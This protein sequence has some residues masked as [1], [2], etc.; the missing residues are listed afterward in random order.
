MKEMAQYHQRPIHSPSASGTGDQADTTP[1][2]TR[3]ESSSS[4]AGFA[5]HGSSASADFSWYRSGSASSVA[6]ASQSNRVS[7]YNEAAAGPT[8]EASYQLVIVLGL[9]STIACLAFLG[10][11]IP[12]VVC[13]QCLWPYTTMSYSTVVIIVWPTS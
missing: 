2:R 11:A 6:S 10:L 5:R 8:L 1:G 3:A 13:K 12:E 4:Q 7:L 9:W